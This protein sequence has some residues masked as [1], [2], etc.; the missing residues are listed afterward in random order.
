MGS[1]CSFEQCATHFAP[2]IS[3]KS[4]P[5]PCHLIY[6]CYTSHPFAFD[7]FH[8][9]LFWIPFPLLPPM[10]FPLHLPTIFAPV[11]V[12]IF[13]AVLVAISWKYACDQWDVKRVSRGRV[14]VAIFGGEGE[15]ARMASESRWPLATYGT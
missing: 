2:A 15:V 6:T 1:Y 3:I 13:A 8:P 9:H 12:A 14:L 4:H 10:A 11:L 5:M 7:Q